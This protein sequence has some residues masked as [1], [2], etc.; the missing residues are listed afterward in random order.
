MGVDHAMFPSMP[1][2][3]PFILSS[4][5]TLSIPNPNAST[6]YNT[7]HQWDSK[8]VLCTDF[9]PLSTRSLHGSYLHRIS[10]LRTFVRAIELTNPLSRRRVRRWHGQLRV[11]ITIIL[12]RVDNSPCIHTAFRTSPIIRFSDRNRRRSLQARKSPRG[13]PVPVYRVDPLAYSPCPPPI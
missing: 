9:Q 12:R 1:A 11:S 3:T 13:S 8:P 6:S 5:L 7:T 2:M 10:T 4:I